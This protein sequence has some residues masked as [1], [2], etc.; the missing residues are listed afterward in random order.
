[1]DIGQAIFNAIATPDVAYVL[2]I[3]GLFS[4]IIAFAVPGTGFA[5]VAAGICLL[6]A[7]VGMAQLPVNLAGILLIMLGIFLFILD[8]KLQS[9]ALAI[10]GAIALGTG[11]IF[12]FQI[13]PEQAGV[14]LWLIGLV[15]LG[16]AAFFGF[17]LN[18]A[19]K[20][21]RLQPKVDVRSVL[22][23]PGVMREPAL[24]SNRFTGTAQVNGEL[25]SVQSDE[26]L[27]AGAPIVVERID[28]LVLHVHSNVND[29]ESAMH[30]AMHNAQ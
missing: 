16:S 30:T 25:W 26:A 29:V 23:A 22:G 14:S 12:L 15:T 1:M 7:V 2:L 8:V 11:S 9:G 4:A 6:L 20:A 5:E 19:L 13:G 24:S 27:A 17:A 28:G 21:M 18:K 10:G 3:L